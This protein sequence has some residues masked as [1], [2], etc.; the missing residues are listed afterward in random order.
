MSVDKRMTFSIWS[1]G[2]SWGK[3]YE[4]KIWHPSLLRSR[5][6][7]CHAMLTPK[8]RLLT[9]EQHSFPLFDQSQLL[10]HFREPSRAKFAIL[11]LSNQRSCFICPSQNLPTVLANRSNRSPPDAQYRMQVSNMFTV[12]FMFCPSKAN[13]WR[14]KSVSCDR[15]E[16]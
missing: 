6:F 1:Y 7:G 8:K 4:N 15:N 9:S 16:P 11:N 14:F 3:L 5:F 13:L 2:I 12:N 10:F